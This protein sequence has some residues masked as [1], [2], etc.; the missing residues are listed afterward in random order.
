MVVGHVECC[1]FSPILL[2]SS[3]L[4]LSVSLCRLVTTDKCPVACKSSPLPVLLHRPR[5]QIR[6]LKD[7]MQ[8]PLARPLIQRRI[9]MKSNV[10]KIKFE[11][12]GK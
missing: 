1:F 3:S 10:K 5:S 11:L 4:S 2:L 6:N 12:I 9:K 8:Y 7:A